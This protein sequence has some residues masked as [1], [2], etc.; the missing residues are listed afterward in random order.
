MNF[1]LYGRAAKA[2][3]LL[4]FTE[5]NKFIQE[6]PVTNKTGARAS[7]FGP[8]FEANACELLRC[9]MFGPCS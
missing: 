1:A 7:G 8:A 2:V 5:E 4:L 9:T 6:I 3:T